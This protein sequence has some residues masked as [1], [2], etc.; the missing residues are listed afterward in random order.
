MSLGTH[1]T[2]LV[3]NSMEHAGGHSRVLALQ[4]SIS[5]DPADRTG[6]SQPTPTPAAT[7]LFKAK[8]DEGGNL[9]LAISPLGSNKMG[10]PAHPLKPG[11]SARNSS[12][13][14]PEQVVE[15]QINPTPH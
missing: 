5:G 13:G 11:T 10:S 4:G 8:D 3:R 15:V 2:L 9:V 12:N 14:Q 6:D 1:E 7:K